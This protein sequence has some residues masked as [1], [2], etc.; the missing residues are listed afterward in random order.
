MPSL[1]GFAND[2]DRGELV[3]LPSFFAPDLSLESFFLSLDFDDPLAL[4]IAAF[5]GPFRWSMLGRRISVT[6]CVLEDFFLSLIAT[7]KG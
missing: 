4:V 6:E 1:T 2:A 5:L 7:S 3:P